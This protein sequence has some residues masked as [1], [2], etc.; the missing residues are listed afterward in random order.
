MTKEHL[1][2]IIAHHRNTQTHLWTAM[3]V[4][5][6]GSLTLLQYSKTISNITL[7]SAGFIFF[8]LLFNIYLHKNEIILN[9]IKNLED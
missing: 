3:L 4:T 6:S 5:I 2:E 7:A 9:L 8:F 1:K